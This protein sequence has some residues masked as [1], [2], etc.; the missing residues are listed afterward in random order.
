MRAVAHVHEIGGHV[1]A[2]AIL[3]ERN[4]HGLP[5]GDTHGGI[6]RAALLPQFPKLGEIGVPGE[7]RLLRAVERL[8]IRGKFKD[9]GLAEAV[10]F[11]AFE[12]EFG[13]G[14]KAARSAHAML[15][16]DAFEIA[17]GC[18]AG[19]LLIERS[20]D[21]ARKQRGL[22]RVRGIGRLLRKC[23]ARQ[24]RNAQ[25]KHCQDLH[26]SLRELDREGSERPLYD[27]WRSA[28]VFRREASI[29]RYNRACQNR[30]PGPED[31]S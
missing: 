22:L 15:A 13:G 12:H 19:K 26:W 17:F 14:A 5:A 30:G 9:F 31:V 20:H 6:P 28:F 3:G 2:F 8:A 16:R 24:Q 1:A 4:G 7:A 11:S 25:C 21:G 29:F 23:G 18:F 27:R 10:R